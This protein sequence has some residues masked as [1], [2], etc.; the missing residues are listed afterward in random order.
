VPSPITWDVVQAFRTCLGQIRRA[1]GYRTDM[2]AE[3]FDEPS[4]L[5]AGEA[6]DCLAVYLDTVS[7]PADRALANVGR[8]LVVV[9]AAKVDHT[10]D[11]RQARIHD[12]LDDLDRA[13]TGV[14]ARFPINGR[15]PEF[16]AA[17]V[18]PV[19]DGLLW[20]GVQARY[21][22]SVRRAR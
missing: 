9:V 7:R 2:G 19:A 13:L 4:K 5:L 1:N 15:A 20:A 16:I 22:V 14:A 18:D 10:L 21:S 8:D 17:A 3:V 6:S 12:L 11:D